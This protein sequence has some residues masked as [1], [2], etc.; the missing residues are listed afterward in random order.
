ML[1]RPTLY[2]VKLMEGVNLL[3]DKM[4]EGTYIANVL[5]PILSEFYIKN[6]QD[7]HVSYGETCLKAS[8]KDG[9]SQKADYERRSPVKKIDTIISLGEE[10]EEFSVTEVSG[11][12]AKNDCPK[13]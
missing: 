2:R 3:L 5:S 8:A 1:M 13:C 11:P 12:P 9:N 7:W 10:D 6:K 4:S